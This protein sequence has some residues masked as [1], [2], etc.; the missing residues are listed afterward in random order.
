MKNSKKAAAAAASNK[1]NISLNNVLKKQRDKKCFSA[2]SNLK[3]EDPIAGHL[4]N[5]SDIEEPHSDHQSE[6]ATE[7]EDQQNIETIE[8]S[9]GQLAI[10]KHGLHKRECK[11]KKITCP[12]CN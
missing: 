11:V 1:F 9:A 6:Y 2:P 7:T 12:V 8:M 4:S 10:A 3:E 5:P